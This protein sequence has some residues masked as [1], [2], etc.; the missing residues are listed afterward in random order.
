[1]T[2]FEIINYNVVFL[3]Q[4]FRCRVR[5]LIKFLTKFIDHTFIL[6]GYYYFSAVFLLTKAAIIFTT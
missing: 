5:G 2:C 3:A 6:Y 4:Y 1:M